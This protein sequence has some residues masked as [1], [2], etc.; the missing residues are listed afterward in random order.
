[1]NSTIRIVTISLL[2]LFALAGCT[3]P[4]E[5]SAKESTPE[6]TSSTSEAVTAPTIESTQVNS[7]FWDLSGYGF[8]PGGQVQVWKMIPPVHPVTA[9]T[10]TATS[11][12]V[13]CVD[14]ICHVLDTGGGIS[15]GFSA[16]GCATIV[17][18]LVDETTG[19]SSNRLTLQP[20]C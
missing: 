12:A 11:N 10:L 2:G 8:T 9:G 4:V 6:S 3:A 20:F 15:T 5:E 7:W 17:V 13:S 16:T 14:R 1:M 19:A 18:W